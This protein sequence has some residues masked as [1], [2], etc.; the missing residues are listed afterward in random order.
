MIRN[1]ISNQDVDDIVSHTVGIIDS[2]LHKYGAPH[3][4]PVFVGEHVRKLSG[5]EPLRYQD[6]LIYEIVYKDGVK[7]ND[8]ATIQKVSIIIEGTSDN[9]PTRYIKA[10]VVRKPTC[11]DKY[12]GTWKLSNMAE[13]RTMLREMMDNSVAEPS[14]S[15]SH[16]Q[17]FRNID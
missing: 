7:L 17:F 8:I 10:E 4:D 12:L 11:K 15:L 2:F 6:E 14:P 13:F 16:L 9:E 1:I 5:S 3:V